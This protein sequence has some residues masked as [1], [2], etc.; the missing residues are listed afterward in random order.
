MERPLLEDYINQIYALVEQED[1]LIPG[2]DTAEA[3]EET[4]PK[5]NTLTKDQLRYILKNSKGKIMTVAYKKKNGQ[6]RVLNA[7]TGVK[8]NITGKGLAY[9][10]EKYGYVIVWDMQKRNYRTVN[11]GTASKLTSMGKTY[12]IQE[13]MNRQPVYFQRGPFKLQ[14]EQ[15]WH[16][17]KVWMDLNRRDPY[18]YGVLD[19]IRNQNYFATE[20]QQ[21][22][23]N[24]WFN[25]KR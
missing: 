18:V 23:L 11:P 25:K 22:I 8:S 6:I 14:G 12:T 9:D 13:S 15:A 2:E 21:N 20:K 5:V 3:G 7:R 19:T 4:Q 1:S 10:P 17:W 16:Q 24:T